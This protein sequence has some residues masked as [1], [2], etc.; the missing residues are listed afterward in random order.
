MRSSPSALRCPCIS[1]HACIL[2]LS[3]STVQAWLCMLSPPCLL[4]RKHQ[5]GTNA[6]PLL[7]LNVQG[8]IKGSYT[9]D[10]MLE[11]CRRG[12]L[13]STQLLLGIDQNLPYLARQVCVMHCFI[14]QGSVTVWVGL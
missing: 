3:C 14:G 2:H 5:Q 8:K 9:P 10:K 11:F 13:S 12:T 4:C 6:L 7:L 1:M